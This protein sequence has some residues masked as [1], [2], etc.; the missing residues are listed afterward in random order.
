MKSSTFGLG[1][2]NWDF[3]SPPTVKEACNARITDSHS[4]KNNHTCTSSLQSQSLPCTVWWRENVERQ[5]A[6]GLISKTTI[7][8]WTAGWGNNW[9]SADHL[10]PLR[11]KKNVKKS[12]ACRDSNP[13]LGARGFLCAVSCFGQVGLN[14]D[15]REKLRRS[16]LQL[17]AEDVSAFSRQTF[18]SHVGKNLWYPGYSNPDPAFSPRPLPRRFLFRP[19]FSFRAAESLTLLT[20]KKKIIIIIKYRQLRRLSNVVLLW[21]R[22]ALRLAI[23]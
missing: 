2:S 13:T 20:T 21:I 10:I 14:S 19:R 17:L 9:P 1:L 5:K 8:F 18:S 12:L 23:H 4:A 11:K 7:T 6:V 16:C 15:P 3:W 22:T